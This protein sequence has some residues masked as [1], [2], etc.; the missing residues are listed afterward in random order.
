VRAQLSSKV[1]VGTSPTRV[2]AKTIGSYGQQR[3]LGIPMIKDTDAQMAVK[4][5]IKP[6]FE[7]DF[8]DCSFGF[9]PKRNAHQ[10]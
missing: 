6:I 1:L 4:L 10:V 3:P 9:R 5:V 2:G 7:E 8:K